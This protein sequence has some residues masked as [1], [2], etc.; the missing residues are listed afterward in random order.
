M[1]EEVK[2]VD[3]KDIAAEEMGKKLL[4]SMIGVVQSIKRPW[5]EMTQ[6]EQDDAIGKMRFAVKVAT[7]QAVRLIGSNGATHVVGTLDQITIKD[8]VKAVVQI[9]KNAENLPELFEAQGGEVMIVCGGG[10]QDYLKDID[11]VKGEPNQGS[12]EMDEPAAPEVPAI[13]YEA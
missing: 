9:G 7:T 8:G 3:V 12:F 1:E 6:S 11:K 13:D 4:E 5:T 10:G 2:A